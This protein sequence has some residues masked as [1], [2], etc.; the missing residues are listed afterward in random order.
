MDSWK[1]YLAFETSTPTI[2]L[3]TYPYQIIRNKNTE[4][5]LQHLILLCRKQ[6]STVVGPDEISGP[7]KSKRAELLSFLL[8][9]TAYSSSITFDRYVV[10]FMSSINRNSCESPSLV[11]HSKTLHSSMNFSSC[12]VSYF[13]EKKN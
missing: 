12:I 11:F 9:F 10:L 8:R 7:D 1:R 2:F 5:H 6:E 4:E 13:Q 3:R